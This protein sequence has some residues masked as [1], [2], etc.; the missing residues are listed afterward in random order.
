MTNKTIDIHAILAERREIAVTWCVED[1]KGIRPDLSDEQVWE[2]LQQVK[3][4]HDAEWGI[5]WTTLET[6][7]ADLFGNAPKAD[8]AE[9]A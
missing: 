6:V 9:E 1:V 3:D 7:A 5:S 4:V 2:V 8:K